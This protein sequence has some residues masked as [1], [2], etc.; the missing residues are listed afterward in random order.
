[1]YY[2]RWLTFPWQFYLTSMFNNFTAKPVGD[3]GDGP[4]VDPP[5]DPG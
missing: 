3:G 2:F 5:V 1:M 4:P